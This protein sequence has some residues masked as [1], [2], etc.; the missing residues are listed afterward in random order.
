MSKTQANPALDTEPPVSGAR[1]RDTQ[2][3]ITIPPT[4]APQR[5]PT[6][7]GLSAPPPQLSVTE[8]VLRAAGLGYRP[9]RAP[10]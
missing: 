5:T 9:V 1:R 7:T 8:R 2:K 4:S 6:Q 3:W 10:R